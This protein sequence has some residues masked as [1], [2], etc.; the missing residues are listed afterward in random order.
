LAE[1]RAAQSRAAS[2]AAQSRVITVEQHFETLFSI[3]DRIAGEGR[4]TRK[5]VTQESGES[6]RRAARAANA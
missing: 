3:Y 1:N 5:C 6:L 2:A 4:S